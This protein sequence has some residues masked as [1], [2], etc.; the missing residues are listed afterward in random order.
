MCERTRC[1]SR[2]P[3]QPARLS[4]CPRAA[5]P[6]G[7]RSRADVD[8]P[9][10][11]RPGAAIRMGCSGRRAME[12]SPPRHNPGQSRALVSHRRT[13]LWR[14]T[15]GQREQELARRVRRM[16][17]EQSAMLQD[18]APDE[19][20]WLTQHFAGRAALLRG[21]A[22]RAAGAAP[23]SLGARLLAVAAAPARTVHRRH[24]RADRAQADRLRLPDPRLSQR[25]PAGVGRLRRRSSASP[26]YSA[27]SP[28]RG[29]GSRPGS[30]STRP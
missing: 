17:I 23:G 3:L 4:G 10:P 7:A 8:W 12:K 13:L 1:L 29:S 19:F 20:T 21:G 18:E 24:L 30:A 14:A 25:A 27:T 11:R 15:H 9:L 26:S 2:H 6:S 28:R 5:A 22:G 16:L